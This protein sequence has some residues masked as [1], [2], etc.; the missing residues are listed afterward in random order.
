MTYRLKQL[1]HAGRI[2]AKGA[3]SIAYRCEA[4]SSMSKGTVFLAML[5]AAALPRD[6]ERQTF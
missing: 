3:A 2:A 1:K 4:R 5:A 6:L